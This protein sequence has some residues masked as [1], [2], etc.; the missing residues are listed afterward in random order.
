[1]SACCLSCTINSR[2]STNNEIIF[3]AGCGHLNCF[4]QKCENKW[5]KLEIYRPAKYIHTYMG[6]TKELE[7][8]KKHTKY[9][10]MSMTEFLTFFL[11]CTRGFNKSI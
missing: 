8:K 2:H 3:S 5:S 4:D 9:V 1:M 10:P 7:G 6:K 11:L